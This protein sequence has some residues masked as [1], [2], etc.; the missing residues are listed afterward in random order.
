[1][2]ALDASFDVANYRFL[3]QLGHRA[4]IVGQSGHAITVALIEP[5]AYPRSAAAGK[6]AMR[7]N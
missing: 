4:Y 7:S 3:G 6:C 1:M 2:V 5:A